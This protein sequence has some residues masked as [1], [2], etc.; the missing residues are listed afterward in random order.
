MVK[1]SLAAVF[2]LTPTMV[3]KQMFLNIQSDI[4]LAIVLV[5]VFSYLAWSNADEPLFDLGPCCKLGNE[6]CTTSTKPCHSSG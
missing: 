1:L 6:Q 4:V 2:K 3:S 5:I